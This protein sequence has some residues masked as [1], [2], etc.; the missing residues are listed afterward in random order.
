MESYLPPFADHFH[1]YL[2]AFVGLIYALF[3]FES[4]KLI[5]DLYA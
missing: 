4:E 2:P 3:T 1:I 5:V